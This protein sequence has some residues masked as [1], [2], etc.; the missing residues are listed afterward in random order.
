MPDTPSPVLSNIHIFSGE[1]LGTSPV[2]VIATKFLS[3]TVHAARV[4]ALW[5]KGRLQ[6]L[7]FYLNREYTNITSSIS[8]TQAQEVV[9][10]KVFFNDKLQDCSERSGVS[11]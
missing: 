5:T 11:F 10:K 1:T 7:A 2:P 6:G 9:L 8:E 3:G 4:E